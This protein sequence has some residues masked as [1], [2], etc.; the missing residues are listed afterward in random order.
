MSSEI[1]FSISTEQTRII[2]KA[3]AKL[4]RRGDVLLLSGNLGA[5]KSELAR[6]IA[7]GLGVT[8]PVTSPTFTLLNVYM[9]AG[10]PLHHFDWYRIEDPE[11]LVLAGLDEEIGR[12]SITLIEW[13]ERAPELIPATHLNIVLEPLDETSR[14]ITLIPKGGFRDLQLTQGKGEA[15]IP[16]TY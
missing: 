3:L 11:E 12:D 7:Q 9:T 13:H 8:G 6:G 2:G 10:T 14:R 5:G 1:F 16:P 4:L 15:C